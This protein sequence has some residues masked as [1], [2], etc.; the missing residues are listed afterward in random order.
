MVVTADTMDLP[1][2]VAVDDVVAAAAA[3]VD[4]DY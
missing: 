3:D 1:V 4:D 2:A